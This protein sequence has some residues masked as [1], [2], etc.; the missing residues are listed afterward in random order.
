MV[1]VVALRANG[2]ALGVSAQRLRVQLRG[3]EGAQRPMAPS[4][5][6]RSYAASVSRGVL[7]SGGSYSLNTNPGCTKQKAWVLVISRGIGT[8]HLSVTWP[9]PNHVVLSHRRRDGSAVSYSCSR[10]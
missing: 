4:A 1:E 9:F 10:Y 8:R 7:T 3:P 6:T 5:A 2:G